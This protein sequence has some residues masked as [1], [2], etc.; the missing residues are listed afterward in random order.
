[1]S[2]SRIGLALAFLFACGAVAASP[3]IEHW[4]LPNGARVY[5]VQA[6]ELPMVDIT[7]VFDAGSARDPTGKHG[8]ACFS[9]ALMD[10]GAGDLSADEIARRLEGVGARFSSD[11]SRDMATLDLRSLVD[12]KLLKPA[13]EVFARLV[14]EPSFPE[15]SLAR[16]RERALIALQRDAQSPGAIVSKAFYRSLYGE[17]P[18]AHHPR[19]DPT[20]LSSITR[21]DLVNYHKRYYV[22]ANA[23]VAIVGDV[24]TKQ[25]KQ[26]AKQLVGKLPRGET[27]PP[28]PEVTNL[29][30]PRQRR[31]AFPSSQTHI[32]IGQPGMRRGDPD[33]FPLYVGNYILGGGGMVS[34][35]FEE[36]REKRG[37]AY[38]AYSYFSPMRR[39]GPFTVG[40]QTENSQRE[41][42]IQLVRQTVKRFIE[43]GP[44]EEE[45]EAAKKHLT[46]GFA[47]RIDSNGDIAGYLAVIGFYQLPLT[48]LDDFI[49]RVEA[50]TVEQIREAFGRRVDPTKLATVV[51]GEHN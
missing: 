36:V 49:P 16:E 37:L 15:A 21:Q 19:G 11:C 9:N 8:L 45:L 7:L 4:S 42:A 44:T 28:V 22:G 43:S 26:I 10:E 23:V 40:L 2:I 31:I 5:L 48:Y 46:G 30:K 25:A 34:R 18:Y 47:L 35:L 50:V 32:R 6:R 13:L 24:S 51:L 41:T 39:K 20:G 29:D 1:M 12:G 33:Q 38:S 17:H 3:T 27:P 14:A